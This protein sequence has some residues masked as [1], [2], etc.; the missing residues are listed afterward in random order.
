[1]KKLFLLIFSF[2]VISLL[3]AQQQPYSRVL[4]HTDQAGFH[5]LMSMGIGIDDGE[6]IKSSGLTIELAQSQIDQLNEAGYEYEVL[7]EDMAAF[8]T[9]RNKP[10]LNQLG[11]LKNSNYVLNGSWPVPEG[12]ELGSVGGFCSIDEMLAHLDSMIANYPDLISVIHQFD[13][14]THEGR[15]VYWIRISDNPNVN[16]DE[17]EVFY[18]G[19]HHAREPIGMQHLLFFMYYLLENYDSDPEIQYIVDNFELYIVPIV[20]MDG[21]AYNIATSPYGGGMWRKNRRDNE[22]GTW[23]VDPNRNYAYMWGLDNTG[24]SP[25]T[26]DET[27]RGPAPF[28][29][30]CNKNMRDF[31]EGH[32]FRTALNYHSYSNLLLYPWGYTDDPCPDDELFNVHAS[33]MTQENGYTYGA[34]STT[35]YPTNGGSDDWMYG[36][37][38][39]K[40]MILAYTPEVGSSNDGFWPLVSRIIPLCQENMWQGIMAAR[41][42]G[43]YAK[44]TD[45]SP[46]IIENTN[47]D[48]DFSLR[49]LGLEDGGTFTVSI[50]PLNDAIASIGDPQVYSTLEIL[51]TIEGSISYT[52]KEGIQSG[53]EILYLLS[54]DNGGLTDSDTISKVFGTTEVIFEDDA[55]TFEKWTSSQWNTTTSSFHSPDK[56]I[57]DSPYGNYNNYENNNMVLND[58]VDLSDAVFAML[59]FWAKWDIESG[60]D[61]VQVFASDNDGA[62]WTPLAGKYTKTGNSNQATGEPV[63]DGIQEEWVKEEMILNEFLGSEILLRF[64]LKSDSWVTGDGFY[65][66][67]L[68]VSIIATPVGIDKPGFSETGLVSNPLPNPAT[69]MARFNYDLPADATMILYDNTGKMVESHNLSE[70][71]G[72]IIIKVENWKPGVYFYSVQGAGI[73]RISGKM[74]VK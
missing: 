54:V 63:Y 13:T 47:G 48:F 41:L 39:T 57:T 24:S 52:L 37:Q 25:Y 30:P 8:Y 34:G 42:S 67:D 19:M 36:E 72:T 50:T 43:I 18:N 17:P 49:R 31:C 53:E 64:R 4:I 11:Q 27:Y 55:E 16:E 15:P 38:E 60:Y 28:S 1:M 56:S 74:V 6:F 21:Y 5:K 33:I 26:G 51:E 10:F 35:I 22:D 61:Y 68:E 70:G 3:Q 65:W 9:E 71:S 7:I 23:G 62:S 32:E 2:A 46:V 59:S 29:E 44:L 20:N 69:R 12:F 66:D 40:D 73:Q 45:Q 14:L 58:P